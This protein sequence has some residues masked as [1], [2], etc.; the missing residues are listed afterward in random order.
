MNRLGGLLQLVARNVFEQTQSGLCRQVG[1]L[2][3]SKKQR[4]LEVEQN[5]LTDIR[6]LIVL[7]LFVPIVCRLR[8]CVDARAW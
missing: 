1:C 8:M 4:I 2:I 5:S 7:F 6:R 3:V